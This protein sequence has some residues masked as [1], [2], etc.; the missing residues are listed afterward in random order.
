M[1]E[2]V[3]TMLKAKLIALGQRLKT[4][5]SDRHWTLADLATKVEVSDTYLSRLESGER[6]PSLAVLFNLAKVYGLALPDLF[7][8]T[9]E[10]S[11]APQSSSS[12]V[13]RSGDR[14][15]QE[16]NGLFYASLSGGKH[17]TDLH[18]L[19]VIIPPNSENAQNYQHTGEEWLYVISGQ[20]KLTLAKEEFLLNPGDAA[21]FNAYIPHRLS[22]N[23]QQGAEILLVACAS[24]NSLLKSYIN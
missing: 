10:D 7:K 24:V 22:T 16:G 4:L 3:S 12:V 14:A 15:L 23:N 21:H 18:P 20:V 6:Q 11:L 9:S 17:L 8:S 19:R 2:A 13:I 1:D 5:R